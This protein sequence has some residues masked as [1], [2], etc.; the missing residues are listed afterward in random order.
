MKKDKMHTVV[1][2]AFL[3]TIAGIL[4]KVLS[5]TY[6]IPLQ[7]LTGDLGFYIYQQVYPIL[8]TV[9]ILS[10]Y[11]FPVAIST[12]TAEHRREQ[13]AITMRHFYFPLFLVLWMINGV[14]FAVLYGLAPHL[15]TWI[16]DEGITSAFRLAA[17]TFL[18]VPVLSLFR[19]VSQGHENMKHTAYSQVIEQFVRMAIIIIAAYL[20]YIGILD[21]YKIG[22]VGVFATIAG[23][24]IAILLCIVAVP[25]DHQPSS[26]IVEQQRPIPWRY[27]VKT[28]LT[29]GMIASLNHMILL[30][31][32]MVDVFT[33][34]PSLIKFGLP[35]VTAM[36]TKG[37][38]DRGQPL[39]Q[40]GV[41]FGSSFALALV[42]NVIRKQTSHMTEQ[43][44]SIRD[45]LLFSCYLATGA[46][47]GLVLMMEETNMLLFTNR[48]GTTSLQI[49]AFTLVLTSLTI[50]AS[51]MLQSIGC[52]KQIA[53][54]I[55][56][57]V[58]IK[59]ILNQLLVPIWSINGSAIATLS[60]MLFLCSATFILLQRKIPAI[61]FFHYIRWKPLVGANVLMAL[62]IIC[63][64][65]IWSSFIPISRL[66]LLCYVLIVVPTGALCYLIILLRY[67]AFSNRQI[68]AFPFSQMIS[69]VEKRVR[70]K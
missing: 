29:L 21:T 54:F 33:L 50:T 17:C 37:V 31:M 3:L 69:S 1:R 42:P 22:E 20:V 9:M 62:Y 14:I 16:D 49:L 56:I 32:Q 61:R 15:A 25:K 41:V 11:G 44:A 64:R 36:E 4:S 66:T 10:L 35:S 58:L 60:G 43:A 57:A 38:F 63:M 18:L 51:A 40:L 68:Q 13:V 46:T 7:N 59:I 30:L 48:D 67:G 5:A 65:Y 8:G 34:V 24:M 39:I 23:M 52:L 2:G 28:C 12:L 70:K 6:R 47:V 45:G 27:Y 55:S 19:G 53:F 26:L